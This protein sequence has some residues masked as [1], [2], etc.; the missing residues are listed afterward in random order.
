MS[1]IRK[2]G[3]YENIS[4][5]RWEYWLV[6]NK[7]IKIMVSWLQWG[8]SDEEYKKWEERCQISRAG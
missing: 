2:S 4:K 7:E 8:S 5:K 6:K 3:I 1:N